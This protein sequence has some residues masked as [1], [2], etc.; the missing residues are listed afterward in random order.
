M[1]DPKNSMFNPHLMTLTNKQKSDLLNSVNERQLGKIPKYAE[2]NGEFS[3]VLGRQ[4]KLFKI[5]K[6]QDTKIINEMKRHAVAVSIKAKHSNSEIAR[7]L[8]VATSFVRKVRREL[9]NE[10]SGEEL[11]ATNKRALSK[12]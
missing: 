5:Y 2:F 11:A 8:K 9:L 6:P 10:N 12:L 7:F 4:S 3:P 1:I